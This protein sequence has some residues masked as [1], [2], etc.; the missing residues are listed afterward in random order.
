MW[1]QLFVGENAN[2]EVN[3][4]RKS[5]KQSNQKLS[6][7]LFHRFCLRLF[8]ASSWTQ[9]S[10]NYHHPYFYGYL[11]FLQKKKKRI[12]KISIFYSIEISCRP[13]YS[14]NVRIFCQMFQTWS[15]KTFNAYLTQIYWISD[16]VLDTKT[17]NQDSSLMIVRMISLAIRSQCFELWFN[18][19]L[20]ISL[21][22]LVF[23][24]VRF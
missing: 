22:S 6:L 15:L 2:T 4:N 14:W 5:I 24:S 3:N 1:I 21:F 12:C 23:V 10:S 7:L 19:K 16:I 18:T 20:W 11:Y 9:E 17:C 13:L 8:I